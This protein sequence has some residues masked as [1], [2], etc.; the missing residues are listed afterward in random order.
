[1]IPTVSN[2]LTHLLKGN[3]SKPQKPGFKKNEVLWLGLAG[4]APCPLSDTDIASP[5]RVRILMVGAEPQV[6]HGRIQ[7]V[8]QLNGSSSSSN[9]PFFA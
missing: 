8:C 7:K 9:G 4:L 6:S 2:L 5:Q 3:P 1:M